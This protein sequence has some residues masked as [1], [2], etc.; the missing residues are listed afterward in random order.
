MKN[1]I[2]PTAENEFNWDQISD[3][4]YGLENSKFVGKVYIN[5]NNQ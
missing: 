1:K 3:A 5:V 2:S 4:H